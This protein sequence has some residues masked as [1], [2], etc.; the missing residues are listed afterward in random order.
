[1]PRQGGDKRPSSASR[2][3]LRQRLFEEQ[4]ERCYWCKCHLMLCG[5]QIDRIREGKFGGTYRYD[6]VVGACDTCNKRRGQV[7]RALSKREAQSLTT[8]ILRALRS[9][10]RKAAT[11]AA[12]A[13]S[14]RAK[15]RTMLTVA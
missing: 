8:P 12:E 15:S 3:R 4:G 2:R 9:Q 14:A 7:T 11:V 6:N 5:M 10:R 13:Q 1:M